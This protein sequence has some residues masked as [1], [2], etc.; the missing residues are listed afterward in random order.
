M[1]HLDQ[2]WCGDVCFGTINDNELKWSEI[3][4]NYVKVYEETIKSVNDD[5]ILDKLEDIFAK[6]NNDDLNPL[7]GSVN[8]ERQQFITQNRL[9]TSISV[10]DIIKYNDKIYIVAGCGFILCM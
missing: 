6:F 8:S 5:D 9:H 1:G 3:Q 10:G 7:S 2:Q 4:D